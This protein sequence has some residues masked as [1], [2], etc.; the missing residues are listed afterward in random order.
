MFGV[1]DNPPKTFPGQK[2]EHKGI[3]AEVGIGDFVFVALLVAFLELNRVA[4]TLF[5]LV[6]PDGGTDAVHPDFVRR[7]VGFRRVGCGCSFVRLFAHT[8]FLSSFAPTPRRFYFNLKLN[9]TTRWTGKRQPVATES[10][11]AEQKHRND[12][13]AGVN[14]A[15]SN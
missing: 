10:K 13:L 11:A 8:F 5:S 14:D 3:L 15:R 2:R 6:G 1:L 4:H 9:K 7:L 12:Q